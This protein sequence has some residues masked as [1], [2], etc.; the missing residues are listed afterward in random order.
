[1][2]DTSLGRL[3][4][5]EVSESESDLIV[6]EFKNAHS[7]HFGFKFGFS[8]THGINVGKKRKTVAVPLVRSDYCKTVNP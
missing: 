4:S 6:T 7:A 5:A 3:T 2:K 1:M 8:R